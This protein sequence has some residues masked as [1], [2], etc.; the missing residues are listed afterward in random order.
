VLKTGRCS[1]WLVTG[2]EEGFNGNR[3]Q[4]NSLSP[5]WNTARWKLGRRDPASHQSARTS[6]LYRVNFE[7]NNL[8]P[9]ACLAF[10]QTTYLKTPRK[11]PIFGDE[12]VTSF[13]RSTSSTRIVCKSGFGTWRRHATNSGYGL[14]GYRESERNRFGH[15]HG[16]CLWIVKLQFYTRAV[17]TFR[18]A[19]YD[20][21]GFNFAFLKPLTFL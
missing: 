20:E 14:T 13:C 1:P 9:F 2:R 5:R 17:A 6:D 21:V 8:K 4:Q 15:S 3:N 19:C 10:P 7:V 18:L 12:L 16:C 11:Q